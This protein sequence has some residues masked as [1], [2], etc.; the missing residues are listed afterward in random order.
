MYHIFEQIKPIL[1]NKSNPYTHS[2]SDESPPDFTN[3]KYIQTNVPLSND[4]S[5]TKQVTVVTGFLDM[6]ITR[7]PKKPTQV[8]DYIDRCVSTLQLDLPMVI[9][10]S[11]E[12]EEL[13]RQHRGDR[14]THII[15]VTAEDMYFWDRR[16]DIEAATQKNIPPYDNQ[17]L[18]MLVCARYNYLRR[19]IELNIFQTDHFAWI[20]FSAGHIVDF[21]TKDRDKVRLFRSILQTPYDKI[22]I[23]WIARYQK[24]TKTFKFNHNAMGGGIWGGHRTAIL[25]LIEKHNRLFMLLL[26]AGY[27]INDD[28]LLF[29]LFEKY[30]EMFETYFSSYGNLLLKL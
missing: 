14:P 13:V 15:R 24:D 28:R 5:N 18:L 17:Y 2:S 22:R 23:A 11:E 12:W 7:V 16:E 9:F 25:N 27:V 19:A 1:K 6:K 10:I 21:P 20:D 26:D 4:L 29:L 30:P 3:D 8:Y